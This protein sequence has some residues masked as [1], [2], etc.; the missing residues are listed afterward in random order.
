MRTFTVSAI[1]AVAIKAEYFTYP[2]TQDGGQTNLHYRYQDWHQSSQDMSGSEMMVSS[3]NSIVL[4][5]SPFEGFEYAYKPYIRGGAIEYTVDLS[6]HGCGCV[7]GV[8]AVTMNG[9]CNG[10]TE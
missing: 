1:I 7:A 2:I 4:K 5:I 9:Q 6:S 8:Y 3:N 10:E